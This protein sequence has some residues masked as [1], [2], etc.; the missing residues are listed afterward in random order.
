ME[1]A[2]QEKTKHKSKPR[3]TFVQKTGVFQFDLQHNTEKGVDCMVAFRSTIVKGEKRS[4]RI[5]ARMESDNYPLMA[6]GEYWE[7]SYME[8]DD[9]KLA[10]AIPCSRAEID[11]ELTQ[12]KDREGVTIGIRTFVKGTDEGQ[13]NDLLVMKFPNNRKFD[14]TVQALLAKKIDKYHLF[15]YAKELTEMYREVLDLVRGNEIE[16]NALSQETVKHLMKIDSE[17]KEGDKT[18]FITPIKVQSEINKHINPYSDQDYPDSGELAANVMDKLNIV[19]YDAQR[20]LFKV[21][22]A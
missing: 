10:Y 13:Y 16:A 14:S 2:I 1:T 22:V 19:E 20:K 11:W 4:L 15:A 21:K 5:V 3:P 8:S 7:V 18:S 9:R 12:G 17:V 6:P